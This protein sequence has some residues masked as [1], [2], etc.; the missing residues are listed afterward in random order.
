MKKQRNRTIIKTDEQLQNCI[1]R[2]IVVE[3]WFAG[4]LDHEAEIKTY[5]DE[6]VEFEVGCYIRRNCILR[7]TGSHLHLVK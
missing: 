7:I 6:I 4:M 3:V 5:N 1:E 2:K